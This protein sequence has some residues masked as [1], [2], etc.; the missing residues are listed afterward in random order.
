M[1]KVLVVDDEFLVRVGI[2]SFLN[3][4]ENGYTI[5]GEAADGKQALEIM[6]EAIQSAPEE[7]AGQAWGVTITPGRVAQYQ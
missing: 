2:K 5:I 4:E 1:R 6:A 3:W 7:A